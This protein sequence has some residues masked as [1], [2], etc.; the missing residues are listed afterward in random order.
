MTDVKALEEGLRSFGVDPAPWAVEAIARHLEMV[1]EWNERVN[2]TA[3]RTVREMVLKH[4]VDSASVLSVIRIGSGAR[5]VDVGTGAGFP[6]VTLKCLVPDANVVL[7]DSLAKRCRF[8]EAVRDEVVTRLPGVSG[9]FDVVWARAEDVG[10]VSEHRE[11][12]DVVMGRAVAE[13]RVLAELC[14]PLCRVG[15][16]FVAMKGPEVG[17]EVE[18][19]S[20]ALGSLGGRV[21]A[22]RE[23]ELPE[24][25]GKRTLVLIRKERPTPAVYP[26]KAGLPER[27]PL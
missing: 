23:I 19:A 8:L 21:E 11:Q 12:Y 13:L 26:R 2:L 14:L 15:G 7:I 18:A 10:R 1:S 17:P 9:S 27:R 3:M 25:A 22:I 4:A 16:Q 5:V 20:T 6:G 24:G